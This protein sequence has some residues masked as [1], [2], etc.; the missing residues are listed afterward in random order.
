MAIVVMW[1]CVVN[2]T[3]QAASVVCQCDMIMTMPNAYANILRHKLPIVVSP[4][5]FEVPVM[6]VHLYWHEQAEQ[7]PV[8]NW[9]RDKLLEL[10]K[11]LLGKV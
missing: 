3:L 10:A 7:D 1:H 2:T 8:N 4:L 5:P 11:Q 9:M 6:P